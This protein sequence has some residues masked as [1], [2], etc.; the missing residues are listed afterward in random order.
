MNHSYND[1]NRNATNFTMSFQRCY[2]IADS[3]H[4]LTAL[5]KR[6][7]CFITMLIIGI[8][9]VINTLMIFTIICRKQYKRQS[10]KLYLCLSIIDLFT[11][12][13]SQPLFTY[14]L[15]RSYQELN[16]LKLTLVQTSQTIFLQM[17]INMLALI[18]YDQYMFIKHLSRYAEI[19]TP[20]RINFCIVVVVVI[21]IFQGITVFMES[22]LKLPIYLKKIPVSVLQVLVVLWC[23]VFNCSS[24][25][26][27]KRYRTL[28]IGRL[29]MNIRILTKITYYYLVILCVINIPH[30]IMWIVNRASATTGTNIVETYL[31]MYILTIRLLHLN[32]CS[33][34]IV[35]LYFN[36]QFQ[37]R[38]VP[39]A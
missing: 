12:L 15:M 35:F 19:V 14:Q 32:A 17:S 3:Y 33:H 23:V 37:R 11:T 26:V 2:T 4:L 25:Y 24:L 5:E 31:F 38:I 16:C 20:K 21:T 30:V 22:M 29:Q 10:I 7:L 1:T 39:D 8:N 18:V 36:R 27:M 13:G 9:F 34:S 6:R 28:S